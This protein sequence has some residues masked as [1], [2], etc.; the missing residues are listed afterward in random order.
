MTLLLTWM[1]KCDEFKSTTTEGIQVRRFSAR[2]VSLWHLDIFRCALAGT[3]WP[4]QSTSETC[5]GWA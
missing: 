5:M 3:Y 4:I 2:R 1:R